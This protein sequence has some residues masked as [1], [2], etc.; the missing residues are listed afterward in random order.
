MLRVR[1]Q[2]LRGS[3]E[4]TSGWADGVAAAQAG[5]TV[6]VVPPWAVAAVNAAAATAGGDGGLADIGI[7]RRGWGLRPLLW[8]CR[9]CR[10]WIGNEVL[11]L[12]VQRMGQGRANG[13]REKT[14]PPMWEDV[15]RMYQV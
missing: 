9:T 14:M 5:D 3:K 10:S 1:E 12:Y 4:P 8:R 6:Q 13:R 15:L 2:V 11:S 7:K